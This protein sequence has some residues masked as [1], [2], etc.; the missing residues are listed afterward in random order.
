MSAFTYVE[1]WHRFN[2]WNFLSW[3]LHTTP[4][5][6]EVCAVWAV[7]VMLWLKCRGGRITSDAFLLVSYYMEC[8]DIPDVQIWTTYIKAFESYRLTDRQTDI[9]NQPKLYTMP[10]HK[11]SN[12]NGMLFYLSINGSHHAEGFRNLGIVVNLSLWQIYYTD[13]QT[14]LVCYQHPALYCKYCYR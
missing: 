8:R 5:Q 7:V 6:C 4:R 1:K 13:L 9:R 10:L 14:N 11:W 12:E 2:V 3:C